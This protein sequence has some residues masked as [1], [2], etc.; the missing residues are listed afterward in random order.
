MYIAIEST[1]STKKAVDEKRVPCENSSSD[2]IR[3]CT[4]DVNTTM[5]L[6]LDEDTEA[7]LLYSHYGRMLGSEGLI[8]LEDALSALALKPRLDINRW[9]QEKCVTS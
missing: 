8:K 3:T 4:D 7:N 5:Q 1:L 2:Y 9:C 6:V